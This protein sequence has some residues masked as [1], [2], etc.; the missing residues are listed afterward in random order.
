[1]SLLFDSPPS[2]F[3]R[4][5]QYGRWP[6][7]GAT[8]KRGKRILPRVSREPRN[9]DEWQVTSD[10]W[11]ERQWEVAAATNRCI[12]STNEQQQ[13]ALFAK[14]FWGVKK[15]KGKQVLL[16][17]APPRDFASRDRARDRRGRQDDRSKLFCKKQRIGEMQ[18][19]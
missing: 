2:D 4:H 1:L 18:C 15:G 8:G 17:C 13:E 12:L 10:E 11:E 5:S 6:E 16:R 3:Y 9:N 14:C 19:L 7:S